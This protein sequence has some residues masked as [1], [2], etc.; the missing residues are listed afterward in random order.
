MVKSLKKPILVKIGGST[1]GSGDTAIEDLVA[2]QREGKSLVVVHGGANVVTEGL[3]RLGIATRIVDGLRATPDHQTLQVVVGVLCGV[4]NKELVAAI[5]SR[6]G[7]AIGLSGIDG[8]LIEAK[9]KNEELGLIGE[10]V[11]VNPEPVE[12]LLKEGYIP[13]IAPS[14]FGVEKAKPLNVNADPAAGALAA[15]LGAEMLILLTD[16]AGVMDGSGKLLPRLSPE[17][18]RSLI[19]SGVIAGGMIPKVEAC[20][21]AL[22]TVP[23]T[24]IVDGRVPYALAEAAKGSKKGTIIAWE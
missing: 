1:F 12:I 23:L 4:V 22:A 14:G 20:L 11:K 9:V 2:L 24:Q 7:R 5:Q 19:N 3:S 8:R 16:V 15:A 18:A 17:E 6:G 21:T 13:V 10:V